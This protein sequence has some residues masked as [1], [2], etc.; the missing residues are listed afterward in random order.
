MCG[1]FFQNNIKELYNTLCVVSPM[2]AADLEQKWDSLSISTDK[3]ARALEELRDIISP[4]VHKCSESVKK[5]SIPGIRNTIVHLKH[6]VL[7]NELLTR[8]PEYPNSFNEQNLASLGG[9]ELSVYGFSDL[10]SQLKESG[11]QLDPDNE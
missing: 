1:T 11:C 6:T 3:N 5:V 8:I 7:Q 9:K 10:E 4:L 2:F